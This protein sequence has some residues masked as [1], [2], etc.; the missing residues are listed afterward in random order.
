MSRNRKIHSYIIAISQW[1]KELQSVKMKYQ[2]DKTSKKEIP[3][4]AKNV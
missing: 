2:D 1:I 4:L 3:L